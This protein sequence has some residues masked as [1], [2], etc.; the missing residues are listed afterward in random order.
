MNLWTMTS[1]LT[2][3]LRHIIQPIEVILRTYYQLKLC[4]LFSIYKMLC[5]SYLLPYQSFNLHIEKSFQSSISKIHNIVCTS[6]SRFSF[7]WS[8]F[9]CISKISNFIIINLICEYKIIIEI[10]QHWQPYFSFFPKQ[11]PYL[12]LINNSV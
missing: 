9:H 1:S 4:D 6:Q 10:S 12:Y 8:I 3:N 11:F 5:L 2:T 7:H